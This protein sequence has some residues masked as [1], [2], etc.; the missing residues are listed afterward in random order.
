MGL[1]ESKTMGNFSFKKYVLSS[2]EVK[3]VYFGFI[4]RMWHTGLPRNIEKIYEDFEKFIQAN[5]KNFGD[6]YWFFEDTEE[7]ITAKFKDFLKTSQYF[8]ELNI[9]NK[10]YREGVREPQKGFAFVSGYNGIPSDDDFIDLD[11][12]EGHFIGRI[13]GLIEES[14][15]EHKCLNCKFFSECYNS[16]EKKCKGLKTKNDYEG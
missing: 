7:N 11:A 2:A 6:D 16:E 8:K 15:E 9:S 4:F 3:Q 14:K 13:T 12:F 1:S 5:F 10:Q